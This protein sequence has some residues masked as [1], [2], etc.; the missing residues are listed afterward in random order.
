[1]QPIQHLT[2]IAIHHS[3][4]HIEYDGT[5]QGTTQNLI[6]HEVSALLNRGIP[7]SAIIHA[8]LPESSAAPAFSQFIP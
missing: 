6:V 2:L 7:A 5:E 3:T 8:F 4:I 1:L